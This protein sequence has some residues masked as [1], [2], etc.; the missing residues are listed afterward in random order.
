MNLHWVC[1]Q[2]KT[3]KHSFIRHTV[4]PT[5]KIRSRW[6]TVK[7]KVISRASSRKDLRT[8][9]FFRPIRD[10]LSRED[11]SESA[12]SFSRVS[13]LPRYDLTLNYVTGLPLSTAHDSTKYPACTQQAE[14]HPR[15]FSGDL[16]PWSVPSPGH[17]LPQ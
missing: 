4:L 1:P 16:W 6:G 17:R 10:C 2:L 13:L 12:A 15:D 9:S 8:I 11:K 14:G 3:Q 7:G 5:L